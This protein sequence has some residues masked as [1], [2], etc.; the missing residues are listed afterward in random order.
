MESVLAW[1]LQ[2]NIYPPITLQMIPHCIEAI[3]AV[4]DGRG[5]DDTNIN[6]T[7][8]QA[9]EIVEDLRLDDFC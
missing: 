1:H 6:G 5:D 3:E 7:L 8:I 2:N 4:R 9:G